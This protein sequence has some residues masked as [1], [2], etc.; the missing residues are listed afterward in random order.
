MHTVSVIIPT[1]NRAI[2]IEKA[3]KSVLGQ[4]IPVLEVLICDD[5]STDNTEKIVKSI[6]DERVKWVSGVRGGRPAIPRNCGIR[7][8]KGE[9]LAF[10]DS[11]DEWQPEKLEKQFSLLEELDCRAACTN[12]HNFVPGKGITG[13][14]LRWESR[15]LSFYDLL[16]VNQ[17]ICSSALLHKSLV[18]I[19][20]GFPEDE[21]LKGCED[22]ALWLRVATQTNFAFVPEPLVT[23]Q[24]DAANSVR[25]SL[26]EER[27]AR[28]KVFRNFADWAEGQGIP[29]MY[30]QKVK[31]QVMEDY[32][33][34]KAEC[35]I[36]P[37]KKIKRFFCGK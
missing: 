31:R 9:W 22:Y 30:V 21:T 11:D 27:I 2:L 35:V 18:D 29:G 15:K 28:M 3:I 23:Y 10:L 37:V 33:R 12:A 34:S 14:F 25:S 36:R 5:G 13:N 24:N 16:P 4:T 7:A 6:G 20:S 1:W 26:G 17:V 8:S 32:V 19:V